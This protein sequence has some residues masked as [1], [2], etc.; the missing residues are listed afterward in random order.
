MLA[1]NIVHIYEHVC[2]HA[3]SCVGVQKVETLQC[4]AGHALEFLDGLGH[5]SLKKVNFMD[6]PGCFAV[7]SVS[8]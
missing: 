2:I 4:I 1:G 5:M 7:A 6:K 3:N 8:V